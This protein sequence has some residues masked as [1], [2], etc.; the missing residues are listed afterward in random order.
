[1]TSGNSIRI[2]DTCVFVNI[3]DI[4]GDSEEIWKAVI[5]EINRGTVKTVRQTWEE[6][7]D[8]FPDIYA[9]LKKYRKLILIPDAELYAAEAI[10]ELRE[11][12]R[13]HPKLINGL[14]V[15]NPAD[16]FLIAAAKCCGGMVVT[17]EGKKGKGF[18]KKI[19][20]VCLNRNVGCLDSVDWLK[21]MGFNV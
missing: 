17:D 13:H 10:A 19:P 8:I 3:R 12:R 2:V 4:H 14:G 18:K 7:Q 9:R 21:E 1:L 15:G 5:G 16:P 6:L 20:Y 11:I